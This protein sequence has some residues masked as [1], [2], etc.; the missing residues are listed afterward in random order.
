MGD[1][2]EL[3]LLDEI[4]AEAWRDLVAAAPAAVI[5]ATGMRFAQ[6][7]QVGVLTAP[8]LPVPLYNRAIGL[9]NRGPAREQDVDQVLAHFAA[10]GVREPWIQ[11]LPTA[12][13][14]AL[15]RWLAARGLVPARRSAWGKFARGRGPVAEVATELAIREIGA[16]EADALAD[17]LVAAHGMPPVL[18]GQL[19]A[20]V[21]RP[22]W[23]MYGAYAGATLVAG[24]ALWMSDGVAWLGLGGTAPA[25][26]R[27]GG[28]GALMARR[29]ADAIAGGAAV[30]ATET[31]EPIAEEHNPSRANMLRAGFR[32]V[33]ARF[34][35]MRP[36]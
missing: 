6:L 12:Q 33:A 20:L 30:I 2:A 23:R 7:G 27:R 10:A 24:A 31:G 16:A 15:V 32:L 28:Q 29:I 13:P 3:E 21:G 34:N 36:S 18:R 25:H 19:I 35:F 8:G 14:S 5:E 1:V 26:R 17:V 22:G 11:I 4:E 9:G